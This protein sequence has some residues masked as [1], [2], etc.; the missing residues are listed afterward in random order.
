MKRYHRLNITKRTCVFILR[1]T[2]HALYLLSC[3]LLCT[4]HAYNSDA[5][6]MSLVS[7]ISLVNVI[8]EPLLKRLI[9][10]L[11]ATDP[12]VSVPVQHAGSPV[13]CFFSPFL[14]VQRERNLYANGGRG[15]RP[16][17]SCAWRAVSLFAMRIC[18]S[19]RG[20]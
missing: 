6:G 18:H 16:G 1:Y 13:L 12:N 11:P 9:R 4:Y 8:T 19:C 2:D 14:W 7:L 17:T 20:S 10:D 3:W 15:A 5:P